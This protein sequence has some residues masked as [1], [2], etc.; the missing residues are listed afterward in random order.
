M[1]GLGLSLVSAICI[2]ASLH[3]SL[4]EATD[5]APPQSSASPADAVNVASAKQLF[6][7]GVDAYERGN[8]K[9]AI[10]LWEQSFSLSGR[11][12]LYDNISRAHELLDDPE[13][14]LAALDRWKQVAPQDEQPSLE[15]RRIALTRALERKVREEQKARDAQASARQ[16]AAEEEPQLTWL[17]W[18]LAG[19]GVALLTGG[20][21]ISA[22]ASSDANS[23]AESC[24]PSGQQTL[25]PQ[26]VSGSLQSA[27]GWTVAGD[28]LWA[29]GGALAVAGVAVGWWQITQDV[30]LTVLPGGGRMT[31]TF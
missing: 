22:V 3:A 9:D 8:Y 28:I 24:R 5:A 20:L 29:T 18:T 6:Q 11:A 23:A 25:C 15:R 17:P 2:S 7:L 31:G 30:E 26:S 12:A 21:V 10:V 19:A 13:K 4:A 14:A 16:S 1:T 27:T